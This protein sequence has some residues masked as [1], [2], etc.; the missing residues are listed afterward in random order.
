MSA[1]IL[2]M[3]PTAPRFLPQATKPRRDFL[4]DVRY[5]GRFTLR[6]RAA[7]DRKDWPPWK[8]DRR[9]QSNPGS[10]LSGRGTLQDCSKIRSEESRVG[11]ECRSRWCA[12]P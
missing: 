11:E 1:R 5:I 8:R 12:Y 6:F 3:V 9:A 4:P 2:S 7:Q 10:K